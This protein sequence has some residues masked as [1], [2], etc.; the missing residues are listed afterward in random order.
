MIIGIGTDIVQI[1]RIESLCEKFPD[2]FV[3]RILNESEK[4]KYFLL[5]KAEKSNFLAKRYAAKEA[6]AKAFGRGIGA[7]VGFHDITIDNDA[8]GKP[9]A[10]V[11]SKIA[12]DK[13]IDLSI[14]DDHPIAVAFA[15][16]SQ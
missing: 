6:I 13:K 3:S 5:D 15:V 4:E 8:K 16:V 12:V 14:S 11:S 1:P 9:F 10:T 7:E 2:E